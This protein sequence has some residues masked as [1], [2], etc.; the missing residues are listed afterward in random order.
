MVKDK[1]EAKV[2]GLGCLGFTMFGLPLIIVISLFVIWGVWYG[3]S[4]Y[5]KCIDK[6]QTVKTAWA[7]VESAYQKRMDLITNI[8]STVKAYATHEQETFTAIT[9]ARSK[10]SSINIDPQNLSNEDIEMYR[11]AQEQ[12]SGGLSRLLVV[13]E[14]Y[15]ELKANQNF[16]SLQ[17]ELTSVE[18]EILE[19][20][21]IFNQSVDVYNKFALKFPRNVFA[22]M[23]GFRER[24]RFEAQEEA[25]NAPKVEF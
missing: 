14:N 16:M 9:E 22:R 4:T 17:A 24:V 10:V 12:I 13:V 7:N 1:K 19:Y 8:V 18:N 15:P 11:N 3:I 5:N 25:K 21:K 23:F 20:R 6:D 2:K